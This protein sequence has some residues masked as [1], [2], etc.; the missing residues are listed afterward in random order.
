MTVDAGPIWST[1]TA[2][3]FHLSHS[4]TM[5]PTT[6][7]VPGRRST[8]S[9]TC[10]SFGPR[11]ATAIEACSRSGAKS[12]AKHTSSPGDVSLSVRRS[13]VETGIGAEVMPCVQRFRYARSNS[14]SSIDVKSERITSRSIVCPRAGWHDCQ[15]TGSAGSSSSSAD[16]SKK[17][18][19]SVTPL[20]TASRPRSTFW[21]R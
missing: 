21:R 16:H 2:R 9:T 12:T 11:P 14:A 4:W 20:A 13:H 18:T 1:T 6:Q 7:S 10:L 5:R 19:P 3:G 17:H 15:V 8:S